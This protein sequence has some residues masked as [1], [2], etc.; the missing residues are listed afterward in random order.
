MHTSWMVDL[1]QLPVNMANESKSKFWTLTVVTKDKWHSNWIRHAL[2]HI[3]IKFTVIGCAHYFLFY[4]LVESL[5]INV[6]WTLL[7]FFFHIGFSPLCV[8]RSENAF[9]Y[10]M[11]RKWYGM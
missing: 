6:F 1:Y 5:A 2:F 9:S 3:C 7:I 11:G 10:Y 8:F 4:P